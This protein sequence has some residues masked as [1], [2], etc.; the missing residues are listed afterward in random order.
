LFGSV[1]KVR[2]SLVNKGRW[3][4][5]WAVLAIVGLSLIGWAVIFGAVLLFWHVLSL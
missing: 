5:R 4:V 3:P 1:T 2:A